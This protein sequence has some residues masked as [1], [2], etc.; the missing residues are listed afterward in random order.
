MKLTMPAAATGATSA[1][2]CAAGDLSCKVREW[3]AGTTVTEL[4]ASC[5]ACDSGA[6][7]CTKTESQTAGTSGTKGVARYVSSVTFTFKQDGTAST[8]VLKV[9]DVA[10]Q[11]NS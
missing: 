4:T 5:Y 3:N 1:V 8:D 11:P 2:I 9:K 6:A 7:T 10:Y